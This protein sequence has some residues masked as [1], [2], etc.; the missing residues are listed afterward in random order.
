MKSANDVSGERD[1]WRGGRKMSAANDVPPPFPPTKYFGR[2][3][4]RYLAS[5]SHSTKSSHHDDDDNDVPDFGDAM[6][7]Q[8]MEPH[9]AKARQARTKAL[10]YTN[11][12]TK[13]LVPFPTL[14]QSVETLHFSP[15]KFPLRR[16]FQNLLQTD[17]LSLLH[18]RS[19]SLSKRELLLPLL[20][21]TAREDFHICYEQ[22]VKR[23]AIPYLHRRVV[24][25]DLHNC[26]GDSRGASATVS[27]TS[28]LYV[29][30]QAFPCIRVVRPGEF[31]IGPHCDV[32]YGHS[33]ASLNFYVP[34]TPTRGTNPLF[35]ESQ[36]GRE[37]WRPL[38]Y[39]GSNEENGVAF[40]FD[41]AQ[42]IHFTLENTTPFTRVSLDFRVALLELEDTNNDDTAP[43]QIINLTN[44]P[45]WFD[46]YSTPP[47][48][49][50]FCKS[51]LG[52]DNHVRVQP[53]G[54]GESFLYST[55]DRRVGF[56]F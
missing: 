50:A 18:Q 16:A 26:C 21:P 13:E 2:D 41:G 34:L 17:N 32:A 35:V 15:E 24:E 53:L 31:S 1:D 4:R 36:A 44:H 11:L 3:L 48:Y 47:G 22:F 51:T 27:R 38:L 52:D 30:Y 7:R 43:A 20:S 55:V 40:L 45:A 10:A 14:R 33:V 12:E 23:F 9:I 49:Y 46:R 39:E 56:P 37:D 29:R 8:V 28:S 42:C 6:L 5:D 19:E 54:D 25:E